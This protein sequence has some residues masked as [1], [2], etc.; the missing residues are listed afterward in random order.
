[1][2]VHLMREGNP[3]GRACSW[4]AVGA[5]VSCGT[6]WARTAAGVRRRN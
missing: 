4:L 6:S 1:L 5:G 3:V 2:N